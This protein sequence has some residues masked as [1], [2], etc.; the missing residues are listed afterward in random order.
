MAKFLRITINIGNLL[1][2]KITRQA[3]ARARC[4]PAAAVRF[5]EVAVA[6][7]GVR[8]RRRR[9]AA[10]PVKQYTPLAR[11]RPSSPPPPPSPRFTRHRVAPVIARHCRRR[12]CRYRCRRRRRVAASGRLSR[13]RQDWPTAGDGGV[14]WNVIDFFSLYIS[15]S[16]KRARSRA[17]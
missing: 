5:G 7:S 2:A 15:R 10:A 8:A 16:H 12:R 1:L 13:A 6:T 4:L 9:P 3:C 17:L 14:A 11:D